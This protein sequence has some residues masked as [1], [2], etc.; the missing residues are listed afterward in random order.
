MLGGIPLNPPR[1]RS[2]A[3]GS[4]PRKALPPTPPPC[5]CSSG[6]RWQVCGFGPAWPAG[7]PPRPA[8]ALGVRLA[9]GSSCCPG[10]LPPT[11][12]KGSGLCLRACPA[13]NRI[14][15]GRC[16]VSVAQSGAAGALPRGVA[17]RASSNRHLVCSGV[18]RLK[19]NCSHFWLWAIH[20][21]L[22]SSG[23]KQPPRR[24]A[25]TAATATTLVSRMGTSRLVSHRQL[26]RS[27]RVPPAPP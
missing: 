25:E 23:P 15:R 1:Q 7:T 27:V 13:A 11:S 2:Q 17:W 24:G 26:P 5:S 3:K 16:R 8:L 12:S 6:W 18:P 9:A 19:P 20:G 14:S 22:E 21:F 4:A 10:P